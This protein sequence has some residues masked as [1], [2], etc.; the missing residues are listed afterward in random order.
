VT[1]ITRQPLTRM[2]GFRVTLSRDSGGPLF[3]RRE[4]K[5]KIVG[6]RSSECLQDGN[7]KFTLED[8]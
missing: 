4:G 1:A 7:Q 2:I 6:S 5:S 3:S 8:L